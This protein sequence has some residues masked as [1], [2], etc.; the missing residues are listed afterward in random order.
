M[1]MSMAAIAA[2]KAEGFNFKD[3][4]YV[5]GHSLGEYSALTV[6]GA[7]SLADTA[8]LLKLRGT[9]M[10]I[11]VPVGHDHLIGHDIFRNG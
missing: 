6:A 11:A 8:S 1:A 9:A 5:A 10:Q 4:T 2:A 3:V 7:L